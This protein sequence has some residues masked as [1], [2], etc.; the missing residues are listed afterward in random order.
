[1][2][3]DKGRHVVLLDK[4][5]YVEKIFQL[6]LRPIVSK[7]GTASYYLAKHLARIIAPLSKSETLY[8]KD[9]VDFIKPSNHQLI[10]FDVDW[11]FTNVPIDANVAIANIIRRV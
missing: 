8:T 10:S 9:F 11:L 3:Q 6:P 4:T 7:I 1:M 5:N 2:K